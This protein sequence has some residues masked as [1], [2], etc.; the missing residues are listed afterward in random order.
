MLC[1]W[2]NEDC[3]NACLSIMQSDRLDSCL[4]TVIFYLSY[5]I[6]NV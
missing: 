6:Y 3:T 4:A 5:I 2:R 1:M